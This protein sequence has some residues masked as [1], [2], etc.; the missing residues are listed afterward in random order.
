MEKRA[1]FSDH[2]PLPS[3]EALAVKEE[4]KND[5]KYVVKL[6]KMKSKACHEQIVT[7]SAT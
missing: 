4:N 3:D 6:K 1:L 2:V 7:L 5:N